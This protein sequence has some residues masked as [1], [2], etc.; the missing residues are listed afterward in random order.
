MTID[1]EERLKPLHRWFA[2]RG[3]RVFVTSEG[4]TYWAHLVAP[5]DVVATAP[6]YGRG[7]TPV[8]AAESARRRY[9]EE[10]EGTPE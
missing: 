10:E 1:D 7:T 9:L 6:R 4:D 8:D 5:S 2:E 3:F